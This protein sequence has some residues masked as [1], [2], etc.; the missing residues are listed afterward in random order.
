MSVSSPD[1]P[2]S[3]LT[4]WTVRFGAP[5]QVTVGAANLYTFPEALPGL[6]ESRRFALI[7]EDAYA[8]LRW[9]QSLDEAVICLP[10]LGPEALALDGYDARL[11]AALGAAVSAEAPARV[12]LI[13]QYDAAAQ[14]FAV[15]LLAPIVLD[16]HVATGKQVILEAGSYPLRQHITWDD[17]TRGFRLAC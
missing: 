11:A 12:L 2:C 10:V 3:S 15:N 7:A 16:D 6:P 4:I 1:L 9:L 5:E 14:S 17:V 13:T 8:P